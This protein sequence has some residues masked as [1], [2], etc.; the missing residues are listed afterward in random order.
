MSRRCFTRELLLTF[1]LS[2]LFTQIAWAG[3]RTKTTNITTDNTNNTTTQ[4]TT[5]IIDTTEL[6]TAPTPFNQPTQ[7]SN[8][9]Q[10]LSYPNCGGVCTFGIVRL[11]PSSSGSLYPEAVMGFIAQFDSPENK[12][13]QSQANYY[14]AL[15]ERVTQDSEIRILTLLADAVEK[16][17]DARANIYAISAARSLMITPEQLL[18]TAYKQPRKCDS[19]SSPS[20]TR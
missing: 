12:S 14:K 2:W 8:S 13:A 3:S 15:R 6:L 4:N 18:S 1:L 19:R 5:T 20:S 10:G 16:C 17:E 7:T 11:T 9:L